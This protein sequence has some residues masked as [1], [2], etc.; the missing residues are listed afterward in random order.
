MPALHHHPAG[1]L[2]G[3]AEYL[4]QRTGGMIGSLSDLVRGAAILAIEDGTETISHDLLE[5]VPLDYAAQTSYT[6]T[7]TKTRS[8]K[9]A[10]RPAAPAEHAG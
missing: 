3:L 8:A 1:T 7:K 4:Y 2:A 10:S 6:T 9:R 5:L